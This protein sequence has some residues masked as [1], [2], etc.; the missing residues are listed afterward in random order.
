MPYGNAPDIMLPFLTQLCPCSENDR[1]L[2][3]DTMEHPL[4]VGSAEVLAV[5][6]C[7]VL[8]MQD[9]CRDT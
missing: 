1:L 4:F 9:G 8:K 2:C 7:G 6:S 3:R 5:L